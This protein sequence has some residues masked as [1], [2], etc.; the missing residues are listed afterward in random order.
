MNRKTGN[1]YTPKATKVAQEATAWAMRQV[2]GR[3]PMFQGEVEVELF[4]GLG[5]QRRKADVDYPGSKRPGH[6][7]NSPRPGHHL[8]RRR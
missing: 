6:C 5:G 1:V 8:V 4:F 3:R 7:A 2:R